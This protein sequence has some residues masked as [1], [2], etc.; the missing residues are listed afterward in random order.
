MRMFLVGMCDIFLLLYL[1]TLAQFD[2]RPI[3]RL[4][5]AD[6]KTLKQSRDELDAI[7]G[8]TEQDLRSREV[9]LQSALT[10]LAET[11]RERKRLAE[12]AAQSVRLSDLSKTEL[13]V[14]RR[15][16][17]EKEQMASRAA[18]SER[19]TVQQKA[20]LTEELA[21]LRLAAQEQQRLSEE[22]REELEQTRAQKAEQ[23]RLLE[24]VKKQ[25]EEQQRLSEERLLQ[26]EQ[27]S[28]EK[29]EQQR[30]VEE[31][32][33]R[34]ARAEEEAVRERAAAKQALTEAEQ[35][36]FEQNLALKRASDAQARAASA[37]ES[38]MHAE[39]QAAAAKR[40]AA[41]AREESAASQQKVQA[42]TQ[43]AERA[44][45]MNIKPRTV[46][47]RIM[48]QTTGL[49]GTSDKTAVFSGVLVRFGVE[50]LVLMPFAQTSLSQL[51]S[52]DEVKTF[53]ATINGHNVRK[54]YV[55]TGEPQLI[56]F[57]ISRAGA[58]AAVPLAARK[59]SELMPTLIAVRNGSPMSFR[60][61]I[62][63][64]SGDHFF[65]PRDRLQA[66]S[67]GRLVYQASGFR[68]TGDYGERLLEGDHIV[69]LEGNFVGLVTEEETVVP[70]RDLLQWQPI[71]LGADEKATVKQ[72]LR[73]LPRQ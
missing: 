25:K 8:K 18:E 24:E 55:S 46:T 29:A 11:E 32:V 35:A 63:E 6:Y 30:Q 58:G 7:K 42:V 44:Y 72:V 10:R 5:V 4:T 2:E 43:S 51:G 16:V 59:L 65:F 9:E 17:A 14:L 48:L 21:R 52:S 37:L 68:G 13:E 53:R 22:R 45:R 23:Q 3:S 54:L 38:R 36:R 33:Q 1:T 26:L 64:L 73:Y 31:A 71:K 67:S 66:D 41:A 49:F 27:S 20:E 28:K 70:V 40:V 39:V 19:L 60:D 56:G 47:L 12:E 57:V 61:S 62:R 69:D 15:E 34:A 50:Y